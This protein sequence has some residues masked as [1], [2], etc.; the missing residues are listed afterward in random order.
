MA[1]AIG[2]FEE[3]V[4]GFRSDKRRMR[5]L[6]TGT[7]ASFAVTINAEVGIITTEALSTAAAGEQIYTV[8][9]SF[10]H[11]GS[12]VEAW[13]AGGTNTELAFVKK[14]VA[15][16]GSFVITLVNMESADALDG[17]LVIGFEV[18]SVV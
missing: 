5:N 6:G 16:E 17:T 12:V 10:C 18:Y 14:V 13:I 11:A 7:G 9:N 1:G 3:G 8:T 4:Y 15:S 2:S